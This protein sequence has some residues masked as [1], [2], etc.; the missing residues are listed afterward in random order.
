[1]LV[2]GL[3]WDPFPTIRLGDMV[4]SSCSGTLTGRTKK[5]IWASVIATN[6]EDALYKKRGLGSIRESATMSEMLLVCILGLS[7]F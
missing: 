5:T 7:R 6:S 2:A 3:A 1:M 4:E